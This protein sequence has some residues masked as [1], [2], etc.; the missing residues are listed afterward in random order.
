MSTKIFIRCPVLGQ[1]D[2]FKFGA[3]MNKDVINILILLFL[4]ACVL[5][6]F[7]K[8]LGVEVRKRLSL[9]RGRELRRNRREFSQV[10]KMFCVL[11]L[12]VMAGCVQLSQG[13]KLLPT[14][15]I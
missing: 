8:Y 9:G 1:K 12:V 4:G 15:N 14:L 5:F 13:R 10:M 2:C 7:Y 11:F 6:F 3:V